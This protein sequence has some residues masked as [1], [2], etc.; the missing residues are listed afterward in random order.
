MFTRIFKSILHYLRDLWIY[1]IRMSNIRLCFI[2]EK[3]YGFNHYAYS[4]F[5]S[6]EYEDQMRSVLIIQITC[7]NLILKVNIYKIQ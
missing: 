4:T 3:I 5:L 2:N 6:T 1:K 7:D